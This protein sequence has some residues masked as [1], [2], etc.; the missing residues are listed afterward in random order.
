[1]KCQICNGE[2]HFY[3]TKRFE[4][5]NLGDVDYHKCSDC[6][7]VASITHYEMDQLAWSDLNIAYHQKYQDSE[8][9]PNDPRWM[10]RIMEQAFLLSTAADIGLLTKDGRWLD[11]GCGGGQLSTEL[12]DS[13][14]RVLWNYDEY[15]PKQH[16]YLER[17]ELKPWVFDFVI[18]TSVFEHFTQR[19]HF[20]AVNSLVKPHGVLG[21]HTLVCETVPKDPGWFYLRPLHC[22]F[23]TNKSMQILFSDWGYKSSVYHVKSRLWL[24]FRNNTSEV[25]ELVNTAGAEGLE[26]IFKEGFVDYWK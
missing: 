11:Y 22:A 8:H 15:M 13:Y 19:S 1:M 14:K 7:F 3:F 23:F 16:R 26:L 12:N 2:M 10:D 5:Y 20:D 25:K 21:L 17:D 24:W 4:Q 6:G 9:N 18:T